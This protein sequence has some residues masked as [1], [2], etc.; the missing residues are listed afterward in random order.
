MQAG[1]F[2]SSRIQSLAFALLAA[3]VWTA[4]TPSN[5]AAKRKAKV[6]VCHNTGSG[7][8][9][10]IQVSE[11]AV[12]AHERHGDTIAPDFANDPANCG[13]CAASCDDGD[14]CTDDACSAGACVSTAT[15]CDDANGCT[16]DVCDPASGCVSTVVPG[17]ACD[18]TDA[19][20]DTDVCAE[21]GSC[22][23]VATACDDANECTAE[24]CDPVTGCANSPTPGT[25][26][27]GG[28]G[29]CDDTGACVPN[30]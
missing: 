6:T 22:G 2:R 26:C 27:A 21:D 3:V 13:G 28:T 10:A 20:T 23:G 14:L 12:P 24:S 5:A 7:R 11:K 29:T 9:V 19:C 8:Q 15:S 25:A 16:D 1:V 17:R 4:A 30:A 18:D